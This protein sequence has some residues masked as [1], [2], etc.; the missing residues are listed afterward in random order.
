MLRFGFE[1]SRVTLAPTSVRPT[2]LESRRILR[3]P[4]SLQQPADGC[5]RNPEFFADL[6]RCPAFF[7]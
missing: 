7:V 5:A 6:S 4:V 1:P 3:A 2:I